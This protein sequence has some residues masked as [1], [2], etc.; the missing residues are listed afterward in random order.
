MST[1][2]V[3][4]LAKRWSDLDPNQITSSFVSKLI[5]EAENATNPTV[6]NDA[7]L[8]LHGLFPIDGSR[9]DFGTA[10]LRAAMKPGPVGMNDL[11]I[12]Q[13]TQGLARFCQQ[14]REPQTPKNKKLLA[15]I[16]YD[17]RSKPSLGL[18]SQSFARIA[19]ISFLQ[20]GMDCILLHGFVPTPLVAFATTQ[21]DAAVGIM[22][23]ASHNPK[24]D[25]G[26][27]V[28]WRDGCQI[29]PPLDKGIKDFIER[30]ENLIPWVDYTRA[31]S[32]LAN[33]RDRVKREEEMTRRLA[34]LYF[35]AISESGLVT[36]QGA[37][38]LPSYSPPKIAYTAMHGVGHLWA[39]RSFETFGLDPFLSVPQQQDPDPAFPTVSFPN[40]EEKGALNIAMSFAEDNGCLIVLAN[41]PDA[42]RLAV[43]E[44]DSATNTWK[45]FTGDQIGTMLGHWIWE[46]IGKNCGRVCTESMRCSLFA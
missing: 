36:G 26:Y 29:R 14:Q 32:E 23:T 4:D 12:V 5:S 22:V 21:F 33:D 35:T 15:V 24:E 3:L 27:K 7:L 18:S 41:D 19:Q 44:R 42:D 20:A 1:P 34:D 40:P 45:T 38:R 46:M 39:V 16:G 13:T 25:D 9:I 8:T 6:Q 10:G 11:V 28:Y 2:I 37:V 17:H 43:A 30:E 31:L